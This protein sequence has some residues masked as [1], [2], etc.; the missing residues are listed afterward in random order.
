MP[1]PTVYNTIESGFSSNLI[2]VRQLEDYLDVL[3]PEDYPLLQEVGLN[4]Y[5]REITNTKFE[6]QLDYLLPT[7]DALSG[8]VSSTSAT[9]ITVDH[10]EYFVLH[11]VVLCESELMRVTS[12]DAS[13]NYLY[14]ERGFAG[15]TAATHDNDDTVYRL[16]PARPEGSSPGWAR[17]TAATQPY[18]YTQIWDAVAEVTG[19]EEALEN[20]GPDELLAMRIDRE[21][22]NLFVV[23]E[24]ALL[25]NLRYQPSTNTG[26]SSGG[27]AQFISDTDNLSSA[28]FTYY[29]VETAMANIATRVGKPNVPDV[30]WANSWVVRKISSWGS[31]SVRTARTETAFGNVV[32]TIIT[33]FG[34]LRVMY[35]RL[36]VASKAY[37]LNMDY[38]MCGPLRGRGF[39][40]A[41]ES[42]QN[43]LDDA[44]KERILGEYGWVVKGEDG[45]NE[46]PHCIIYGISTSS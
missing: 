23:M 9:R 46:G 43:T 11:D 40:T 44:R 17:Q 10:A 30:I 21:M 20:Y 15:S 4:S 8:A 6:W 12:I 29:D 45:S 28:P 31:G 35:D 14:V 18:N 37:L 42:F 1:T 5:D 41:S 16:G 25:N 22:Q 36:I 3:E 33:N 24:Q 13:N 38:I 2:N 7:Q 19:T 26:R 27:L 39:M 34:P 32:D